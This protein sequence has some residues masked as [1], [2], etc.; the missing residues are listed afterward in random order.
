M[1]GLVEQ[2]TFSRAMTR[3]QRMDPIARRAVW[4]EFAWLGLGRLS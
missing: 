3:K 4:R 1:I 2:L